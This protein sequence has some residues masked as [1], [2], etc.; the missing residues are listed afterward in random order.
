[1]RAVIPLIFVFLFSSV[2]IIIG[3]IML[4]DNKDLSEHGLTTEGRV[5]SMVEDYDSDN[6]TTYYPVVEFEL[7]DGSR[8]TEKM[9]FGSNPPAYNVGD[10]CEV[11]YYAGD[12]DSA[13]IN[14]NF[15]L[16]VFP[17]IF[18]GVG[19]FIE[20]IAIA[21]FIGVWRKNKK[22][23]FESYETPKNDNQENKLYTKNRDGDKQNPF[24]MD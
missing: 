20:L 4:N 2:F 3:V 7:E 15:Q 19:M 24:L 22:L 17:W 10:A 11:I 13:K 8:V 9:N 5:V 18:I 14:S 21:I 6:G 1:M 16:F 23:V 12:P